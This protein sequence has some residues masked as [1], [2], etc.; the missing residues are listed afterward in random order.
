MSD[1]RNPVFVLQHHLRQAGA[2]IAGRQYDEAAAHIDKALAID[3]ASL[4]A[5]T[6][7][8]RIQKA[9]GA[10]TQPSAP[11]KPATPS[12]PQNPDTPPVTPGR[13]VPSGVNAASWLDFEQRIQERRYRALI[14]AAT[15]A[16]ATGDGIAARI[17]IE[18]ARE[19]R[20]EALE[21]VQLSGRAALL[22]AA[23]PETQNGYL[24]P[25][26]FRAVSMLLL[27]VTLL[28]GLDW[29]RSDGPA[30][31]TNSSTADAAPP[32]EQLSAI[33]VDTVVPFLDVG[34]ERS[35]PLQQA[36][37]L[38]TGGEGDAAIPATAE[39]DDTVV[40]ESAP[41]PVV[42]RAAITS[43]P[44]ATAPAAI[45]SR[46]ETPDS[47]VAP[48]AARRDTEETV[49]TGVGSVP[50]GETPDDYVAPPPPRRDVAVLREPSPVRPLTPSPTPTGPVANVA[51]QPGTVVDPL[52]A[53]PRP[54]SPAPVSSAPPLAA[55]PAV[56]AAASAIVTPANDERRVQTVLQQYVRAY[57][58]LDAR[59]ARAVW[60]TVPEREL[61]NAFAELQSQ[62]FVFDKCDITVRG[63]GATASCT[64][65]ASYARKIGGQVTRDESRKWQFDL[66]RDGES[67]KIAKA[68]TRK[69]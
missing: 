5:L 38:G 19:L 12:I 37:L 47:Y 7:R 33:P 48:A 25:R 62:H 51:R 34:D 17:A 18:E 40:L 39:A 64:G 6:L 56:A 36:A 60:P 58:D 11:S 9:R 21:V 52:G 26:T 16:I 43:T 65:K 29:L 53:S 8:D 57:G 3:P 66:K 30:L 31:A 28:T 22:P 55:P 45:P 69:R 46:G 27:G 23:R 42:T 50:R 15:R 24:G 14:E 2:L 67:W 41:A 32:I 59:A 35:Q 13:F 4:A 63:E 10:G 44:P 1:T 20:P 61:A 54:S 68:E 49:A